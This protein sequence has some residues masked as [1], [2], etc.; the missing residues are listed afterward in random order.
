MRSDTDRTLER[1][2]SRG[3]A[4]S[5][6][7]MHTYVEIRAYRSDESEPSHIARCK[8]GDGPEE[9]YRCACILS[10]AIGIEA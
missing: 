7:H 8:D 5:I 6:H 1:I 3:Y 2:R 4:I 9:M 10:H